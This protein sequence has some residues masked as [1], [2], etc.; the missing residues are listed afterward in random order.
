MIGEGEQG[1]AEFPC[2]RTAL[3]LGRLLDG[4]NHGDRLAIIG[5][6]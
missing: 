2:V 3:C 1:L 4:G 6:E 5:E